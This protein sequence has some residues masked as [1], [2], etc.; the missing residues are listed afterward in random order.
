MRAALCAAAL[1]VALASCTSSSQQDIATLESFTLAD[2]DAANRWA[3]F[4]DDRPAMQCL[5]TLRL[6]IIHL[7]S[8]Q[9]AGVQYGAITYAQIAGDLANPSGRLRADC[10]ALAAER[11]AQVQQAI[12]QLLT[13]AASPGLAL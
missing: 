11:K 3:V 6:V 10:A 4:N 13:F 7:Q 5:A 8:D 12:G 2:V 9:A 1:L